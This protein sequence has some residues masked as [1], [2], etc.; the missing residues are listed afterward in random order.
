MKKCNPWIYLLFGAYPISL[1]ALAN[2]KLSQMM[3]IIILSIIAFL[4]LIT[5][6]A[7]KQLNVVSLLAIL[8]FIFIPYVIGK[9]QSKR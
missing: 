8:L 9:K 3:Q 6:E 4:L 1:F 7:F 2:S 5:A